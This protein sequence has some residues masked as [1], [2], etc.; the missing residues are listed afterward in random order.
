MRN[1]I[2]AAL[3]EVLVVVESRERGG[4]LITA[5]AAIERSVDVMAVPGSVRNR[6]AAGTNQ[7]IRDGARAGHRR[8]RRAR[9]PGARHPP[10]R[11]CGLRPAPAAAGLEADVLAACRDDPRT[12]D[13]I[14]VGL[15]LPIAEAAMA[16]ARLERTGWVREAGG[17]FEPVVSRSRA[18]MR[19]YP[20]VRA[21]SRPAVGPASDDAPDAPDDG[22]PPGRSTPSPARC[23]PC[24]TTR[25][26]PTP[27]TCAASPRGRPGPASRSRAA[28]KR[29]NLRRYLAFLTTREYA[30]RSVARK[31]A[32]LRRYFKWL[33]RAGHLD[34]DPTVGLQARGG[35]GRLPRVLERRDL[36][37]LLEGALPEDEPDWR[38]RRDDAVLEVLY[39]SGL[40]VSELCGL[41]ADSLDL[42]EGAVVSGARAPSSGGSRC[43]RRP[44][45]PCAAGWASAT[46]CW[47]PTPT[48]RRRSP[49][50][51]ATSG[52]GR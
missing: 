52:A 36:E 35:D 1:R 30:R 21:P 43:R 20:P 2:I 11:S 46:R 37:E 42:D 6:A 47:P 8:R 28:V 29:T 10:G 38:R 23:P 4:S 41:S 32:A 16:L 45:R 18:T 48:R 34:V 24:R 7:L 17:W 50:C 27:R 49:C 33:V 26:P 13:E 12:L 25:W 19:E 51:S 3:S 31:A 44:W 9:R 5:Q 40:R 39:G 15:D 22:S 14:V